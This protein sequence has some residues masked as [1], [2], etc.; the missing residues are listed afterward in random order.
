MS[1]SPHPSPFDSTTG[2]RG[3]RQMPLL[4]Q[5]FHREFH[6]KTFA[7]IQ[8]VMRQAMGS[9]TFPGSPRKPSR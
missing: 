1:D 2:L 3:Q 6:R 9:S 8:E 5:G 7:E 4:R